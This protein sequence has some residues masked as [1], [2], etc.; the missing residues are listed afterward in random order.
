VIEIQCGGEKG[1]GSSV[2]RVKRG[3]QWGGNM[4]DIDQ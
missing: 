1:K 2:S 4:E 3:P